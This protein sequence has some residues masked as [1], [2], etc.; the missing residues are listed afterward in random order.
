MFPNSW[1]L[2]NISFRYVGH[3]IQVILKSYSRKKPR[4]LEIK[5]QTFKTSHQSVWK[6]K[7]I[8]YYKT[9]IRFLSHYPTHTYTKKRKLLPT[10]EEFRKKPTRKL[11]LHYEA[12]PF[13]ADLSIEISIERQLMGNLSILSD[14]IKEE[15]LSG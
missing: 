5:L 12:R 1:V 8:L 7:I 10:F 13:N 6:K 15:L 2:G 4:K 14:G 11:Y 3:T 9:K